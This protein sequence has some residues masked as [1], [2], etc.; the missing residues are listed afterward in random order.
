MEKNFQYKSCRVSRGPP[1]G[2]IGHDPEVN[3]QSHLKVKSIFSN[4]N[5]HFWPRKWKEQKIL[6]SGIAW[7]KVIVM[8]MVMLKIKINQRIQTFP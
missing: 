3:D 1:N 6:R 4:R 2:D 5:P 8:V 7:I